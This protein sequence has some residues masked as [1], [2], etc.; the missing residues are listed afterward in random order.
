MVKKTDISTLVRNCP[1][2]YDSNDPEFGDKRKVDASWKAI[3]SVLHVSG[4]KHIYICKSTIIKFFYC[5]V[6]EVQKQWLKCCELYYKYRSN[7][8]NDI[9]VDNDTKA[10]MAE[11]Q[12]IE[13]YLL[14]RYYRK[15]LYEI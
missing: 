12:F 10:L 11:M 2:L 8:Q 4:K 14:N 3:A 15:F 5:L 13:P 1:C 9:F 6:L 7:T